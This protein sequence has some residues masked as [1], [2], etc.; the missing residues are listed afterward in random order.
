MT[1]YLDLDPSKLSPE[2]KVRWALDISE[3]MVAIC[4][5]GIRDAKPG[6]TEREMILELRRRINREERD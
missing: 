1:S 2:E 5:N 4:A 6:I 3:A